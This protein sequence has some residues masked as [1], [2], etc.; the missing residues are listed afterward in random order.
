M[1]GKTELKAVKAEIVKKYAQG[2]TDT[3]SP[4]VQ[5]ALITQRINELNQHFQ[6]FAKDHHSKTGLLRLVGQ[7]KRLL[8][9]L[10]GKD[11]KRYTKLIRSLELR[12]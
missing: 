3:G 7:R 12:K 6:K 10:K 8:T 9:Y 5:I 11:E 2:G 1:R 4:E